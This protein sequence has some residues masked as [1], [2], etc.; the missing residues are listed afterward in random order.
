MLWSMYFNIP[1]CLKCEYAD[2]T[3]IPGVHLACGP[4]F[5]LDYDQ[6]IEDVSSDCKLAFG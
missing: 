4:Y 6:S 1:S 5:E 2:E 3:P